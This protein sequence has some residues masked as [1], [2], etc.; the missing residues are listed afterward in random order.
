MSN[1][2]RMVQWNHHKRIYDAC[3]IGAIVLFVGA[4][5]GVGSLV[6]R[7]DEAISGPILLIRALA[8]CAIVML[9]IILCIGPLAR[10]TPRAAPLLY[11]RRH[12]GVSMFL[13]ALAHATLSTLYYGGF[14]DRNPIVAVLGGKG[15]NARSFASLSAFPFEFLG[16]LALAILF[17]MAATSHDF[18]LKTLSPRAW[19]RLHMAVYFA[20]ALVILHACFGL[21]QSERSVVYPMLLGLG[22]A[23]VGGLHAIAGRREMGKDARAIATNGNAEPMWIDIGSVDEI[24]ESRAKVVCLRTSVK[25]H[26]R[27]RRVAVYRNKGAISALSNVCA[28]QGGPLGEG[29]IV[30]GCVTC[31]WHGYQYLA[32]N[33]QSPPPFTERVPTYQVRV[34]GGRIMLNPEALL[35][36]T[37]VEPARFEEGDA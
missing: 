2:Y 9:H 31:P 11:N 28:H 10:L 29:K 25:G 4:F 36:G 18:W 8:A 32:H 24:A 21:L 13:V 1:A 35:A 16:F 17:A 22:V 19:K 6:H 30:D 33:G 3:V 15:V 20:Y 7:G 34:Q 27:T 37:P 12:L 26:E 23:I 5:V 14:A